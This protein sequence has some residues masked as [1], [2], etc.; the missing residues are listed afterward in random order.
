MMHVV[1]GLKQGTALRIDRRKRRIYSSMWI[2]IGSYLDPVATW[3]IFG[4]MSISFL[5]GTQLGRPNHHR[6]SSLTGLQFRVRSTMLS[7]HRVQHNSSVRRATSE[8]SP[9]QPF[10]L[11]YVCYSS[12]GRIVGG[13]LTLSSRLFHFVTFIIK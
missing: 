6:H 5:F 4:E 11:F 9:K 2:H 7:I 1:L 8:G 12:R 3:L 13:E 10:Q